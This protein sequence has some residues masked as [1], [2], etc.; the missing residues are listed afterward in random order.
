M[1][2]QILENDT[3]LDNDIQDQ[4]VPSED[5]TKDNKSNL[6]LIDVDDM[7]NT[8]TAVDVVYKIEDGLHSFSSDDGVTT[9]HVTYK[10]GQ[11]NGLCQM[12]ENG[13]LLVDMIYV[14]DILHGPLKYYFANKSVQMLMNYVN[15]KL[16]GTFIQ[17]YPDGSIQTK[18]VYENG[19]QH[20]KMESFDPQGNLL[21]EMFYENGLLEGPSNSFYNGELIARTYYKEGVE[22]MNKKA[23]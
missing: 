11:K 17:Y 1:E 10:D 14:K 3:E 9:T 19:L 15:N 18:M 12:T 16:H 5:G 6:N 7:I 21:Q 2:Q 13:R 22:I 20:G 23:V 8:Q 4:E